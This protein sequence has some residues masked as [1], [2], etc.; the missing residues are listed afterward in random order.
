MRLFDKAEQDSG[1][2]HKTHQLNGHSYRAYQLRFKN[3][4]AFDLLV[5]AQDEWVTLTLNVNLIDQQDLAVALGV[6]KPESSLQASGKVQSIQQ[7]H[8]FLPNSIAYL[9]HVELATALT[10]K[11]GNSLARM[12]SR[13]VAVNQKEKA[14]A[15]IRN[16]ECQNELAAI[17]ASWPRTVVGLRDMKINEERS[18]IKASMI[19]ES[20][21][22]VVMEALA[23]VQG[24]IPS[25]LQESPILGLGLGL[26]ANKLNAAL[27]TIWTDALQTKYHC[28]PLED[29]QAALKQ[30]NPAAL[31][32]FTGMVQGVKGI[33]MAVNDFEIGQRGS[34]PDIQQLDAL[35]TLSADD[36]VILFNMAKAF[37]PPLAS[38]QLPEDGSPVDIS[39]LMPNLGSQQ[40]GLKL[41]KKG[42]HLALYSGDKSQ[43][44]AELLAEE[45]PVSNGVMNFSA[46]YSRLFAPLVPI[47]E[48]NA[49]P[50]VAEQFQVLKDLN[51]RISMDISLSKDGIDMATIADMKAQGTKDSAP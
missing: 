10:S 44:S 17:T 16:P 33:G 28:E 25:Y 8:G 38:V 26:D 21:N 47:M 32:M 27:A 42:Q 41:A 23:S 13:L 18:L 45:T 39:H 50:E 7:Q 11:E 4:Q 31:A 24:Y 49:G 51:M 37:L 5:S 34:A 20:N 19:V 22:S 3:G 36:P 30:S 9:D 46:D 29:M 14:L 2:T 35:L 40:V 1:F 43:A 15:R 6:S 12:I 48:Q